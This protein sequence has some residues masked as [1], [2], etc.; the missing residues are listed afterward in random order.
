MAEA[1]QASMTMNNLNLLSNDDVPEDG[2][3]GE[4]CRHRGFSVDDQEWDMIDLE[5]ICEVV[6]S[7]PSLVGMSDH[8][9]LVT[10]VY[11]LRR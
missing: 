10:P 4:D 11:Q 5:S 1:A 3:E 7:C 9:Y 8:H 2:E 6:Y